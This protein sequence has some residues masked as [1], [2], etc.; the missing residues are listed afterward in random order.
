MFRRNSESHT[1]LLLAAK[2]RRTKSPY[3]LIERFGIA[4]TKLDYQ[5]PYMLAASGELEG[6]QKTIEKFMV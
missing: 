5:S 1:I 4:I 6:I 2:L 3:S